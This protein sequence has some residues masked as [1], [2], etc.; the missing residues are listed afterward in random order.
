MNKNKC[1]KKAQIIISFIMGVGLFL[2]VCFAI[3]L[4]FNNSSAK[5]FDHL[6]EYNNE[7]IFSSF[8]NRVMGNL[9]KGNFIINN[10]VSY[11]SNCDLLNPNDALNKAK[12]DEI[13]GL[14]KVK[15]YSYNIKID[16]VPIIITTTKEGQNYT[17]TFLLEGKIYNAIVEKK[18]SYYDCVYLANGTFTTGPLYK[19][20]STSVFTKKRIYI[21]EI[22][23]EGQFVIIKKNIANC[24]NYINALVPF[25]QTTKYLTSNDNN[26]VSVVLTLW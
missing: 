20:N 19:T 16:E 7:Y 6:N 15:N 24:G 18:T 8:V 23:K 22:D 14:F 25:K 21:E 17:G 5:F 12:Y 13:A 11:L 3:I 26:I 4:F 10:S 1:K 2:S 9:S